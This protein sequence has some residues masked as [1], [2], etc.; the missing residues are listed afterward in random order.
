M[1]GLG[2]VSGRAWRVRLGILRF[3]TDWVRAIFDVSVFTR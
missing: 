3:R 1:A 2:G